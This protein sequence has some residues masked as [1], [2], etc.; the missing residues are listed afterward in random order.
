MVKDK[1]LY[2]RFILLELLCALVSGAG[3]FELGFETRGRLTWLRVKATV[4]DE[5]L[6]LTNKSRLR[7]EVFNKFCKDISKCLLLIF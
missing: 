5:K 3:W 1:K 2:L 4:D 7:I 6:T